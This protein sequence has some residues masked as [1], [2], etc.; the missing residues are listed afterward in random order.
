MAELCSFWLTSLMSGEWAKKMWLNIQ[1]FCGEIVKSLSHDCWR[2]SSGIYL[3]AIPGR[4]KNSTRPEFTPAT[5]LLIKFY[6]KWFTK[7]NGRCTSRI[8][9]HAFCTFVSL[10][11]LSWWQIRKENTESLRQTYNI[12][13]T[14]DSS[15]SN[16]SNTFYHL[17]ADIHPHCQIYNGWQGLSATKLG[18]GL[19]LRLRL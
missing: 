15:Y 10:A 12:L 11:I 16:Y 9:T 18:C 4:F 7:H 17:L 3:M 13:D 5:L 14:H 1:L 6:Q 2:S 8:R 19:R